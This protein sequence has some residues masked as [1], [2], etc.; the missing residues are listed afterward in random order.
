MVSLIKLVTGIATN[1]LLS[2]NKLPNVKTC[3]YGWSNFSENPRV[4][5]IKLLG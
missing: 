1:S 2:G 5:A 4:R 3:E